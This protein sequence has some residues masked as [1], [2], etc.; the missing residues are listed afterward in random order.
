MHMSHYVIVLECSKC[1]RGHPLIYK[2]CTRYWTEREIR[3]GLKC[4]CAVVIIILDRV[5]TC[6]GAALSQIPTGFFTTPAC[7]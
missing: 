5:P 2:F 1:T 6:V 7:F 3:D 4:M